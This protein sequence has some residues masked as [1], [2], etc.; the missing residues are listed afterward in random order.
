M[1]SKRVF[2]RTSIL[3]E[4]LSE[5][6]GVTDNMDLEAVH[7]YMT[8]GDGVGRVRTLGEVKMSAYEAAETLS[9]FGS[10]PGFFRLD[11]QGNDT[12][13]FDDENDEGENE[14]KNK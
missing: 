3:V 14:A 1:A 8:T 12:E 13:D 4:I 11:E 10:E 6:P 2:Y 5:D 9:E 7:E